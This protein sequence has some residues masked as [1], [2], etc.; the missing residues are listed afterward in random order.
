MCGSRK[1]QQ[2]QYT[3]GAIW[4]VIANCLLGK[5]ERA[6]EY[7]RILNPI[8]HARTK[9]NAMRY[10]VEPYVMAADVYASPHMQ[11]RGGWT[12]YT[13]S[14]SWFYMAGLSY[15]LGITKQGN[16]L[17]IQPCL[18]KEWNEVTVN[19]VWEETEYQIRIQGSSSEEKRKLLLDGKEMPGNTIS[20]Q[21]DGKPHIVKAIRG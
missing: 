13:G 11:G 4:S 15:L 20:L 1:W 5:S 3:H 12:W 10:K 14:S 16:Q 19:M 9:E 21:K 6:A 2:Q 17:T 8:E 18:P 7:F